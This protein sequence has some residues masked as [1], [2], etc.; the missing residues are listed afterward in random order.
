MVLTKEL[1][2]LGDLVRACE[3]DETRAALGGRRRALV[4]R[5]ELLMERR[6][7]RG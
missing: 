2:T 3:A 7:E 5:Y 1:L 4:L 6:R